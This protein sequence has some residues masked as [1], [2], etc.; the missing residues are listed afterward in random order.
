MRAAWTGLALLL[1]AAPAGAQRD[2]TPPPSPTALTVDAPV[3]RPTDAVFRVTWDPALDPPGNVPVPVYRWSAGFNDGT[4][5]LQGA[6]A[7]SVLMLSMPY[8]TSGATSGFVCVLAQDAAGNVSPGV[9]CAKF[10]IPARPSTAH[11][12]EYREPTTNADG[13]PLKDLASIRVYWRVDDGPETVVTHPASSPEGGALRQLR[14]TVP[15]MSGTLS[16]TVTAVDTAGRESGRSDPVTKV[17][18]PTTGRE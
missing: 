9:T 16:V 13:T 14:L 7:G 12:I 1:V 11:T 10:A 4:G 17:I 6:V 8:H 18:T 15:A 3:L 5:P 2:T